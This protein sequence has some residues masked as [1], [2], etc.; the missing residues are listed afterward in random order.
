[1]LIMQIYSE[2][3]RACINELC[4]IPSIFLLF[5]AI[6]CVKEVL[7]FAKLLRDRKKKNSILGVVLHGAA[8]L[9]LCFIIFID[10][11]LLQHGFY[12]PFENEDDVVCKTGYVTSIERDTFSPRIFL[13]ADGQK[14]YSYASNLTIDGEAFY[15]LT[16]ETIDVGDMIEVE[17]LPKSRIILQCMITGDD[18]K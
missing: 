6:L 15:C 16:Y 2:T 18:S 5:S 7:R 9:I 4:I 10:V 1:M 14:T 13:Q 8:I 12:L 3:I 17:Y 11:H